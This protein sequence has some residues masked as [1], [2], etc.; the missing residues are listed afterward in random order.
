[1]TQTSAFAR[2]EWKGNTLNHISYQAHRFI[3]DIL[4][5]FFPVRRSRVFEGPCLI[6][7]PEATEEARRFEER[8]R[9][10]SEP[11]VFLNPE[12][13]SPF[14]QIPFQYQAEI[15]NRLVKLPCRVWLGEARADKELAERLLF[16]IPLWKRD[17]VVLVP[18]S[19]SLDAYAALIDRSDVFISG[20]T[21]PLHLAAAWKKDRMGKRAFRNRTSVLGVFGATPPRLSGYDSFR[22]DF[23]E[24]EQKAWARVH[25]SESSCRNITCMHKMA[26]VC[27]AGGCFQ[28]LNVEAILSDVRNRLASAF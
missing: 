3:Y 19:L 13:A 21:G 24:A 14:T 4:H 12:T 23:L 26:K 22:W 17:R 9:Q 5:P 6:L 28:S 16:T 25:Q 15:L 11:V 7:S 8:F 2:N 10:G 18:S 20:D 27:D 1:M